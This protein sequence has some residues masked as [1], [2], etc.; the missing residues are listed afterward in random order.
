MVVATCIALAVL[1]LNWPTRVIRDVVGRRAPEGVAPRS[2]GS[3]IVAGATALGLLAA[4]LCFVVSIGPTVGPSV[5]LEGLRHVPVGRFVAIVLT[6]F[7]HP[8]LL[9]GV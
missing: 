9:A 5:A 8:T 6:G 2:V 3:P 4:A 7:T 1:V